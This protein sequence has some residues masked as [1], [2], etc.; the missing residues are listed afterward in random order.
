MNISMTRRSP[1]LRRLAGVTLVWLMLAAC[2]SEAS[3]QMGRFRGPG[4]FG[5]GF[6]G[7]GYGGF[8]GP[9]VYHR[10][11]GGLY[12]PRVYNRGYGGYYGGYG[13]NPYLFPPYYY[14]Y[15]FGSGYGSGFGFGF[16]G[17]YGY[18]F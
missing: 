1:W 8:N 14:G 15:G 17:G 3:A 16:G 6:F 10:G 4:R 7:R 12:G 13:S 5:G 2:T 11:Y 9:R 18:P